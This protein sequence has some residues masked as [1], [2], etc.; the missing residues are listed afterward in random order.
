MAAG[1]GDADWGRIFAKFRSAVDYP[2]CRFWREL[3]AHYPDAK[4]IHTVRDPGKWFDS[5]QATIFAPGSMALGD[6]GPFA[7]FF[8]MVSAGYRGHMHDRDF[9]IDYFER[10]N[11]TVRT[12]VPKDRLLVFE[13]SQGWEPHCTFLGVPVPDAPFPRENTTDQFRAR[14]IDG[15]EG[16]PH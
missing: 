11:E 13:T 8:A 7:A 14:F 16:P 1:A 4:V 3:M 6:E 5:T 2:S 12:T 15:G 10:H 9:M